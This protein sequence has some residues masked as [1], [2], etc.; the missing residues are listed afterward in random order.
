ML[1]IT[2]IMLAFHPTIDL[3]RF[4][5][6]DIFDVR[7]AVG[8]SISC[9]LVVRHLHC[10]VRIVQS[11][12]YSDKKLQQTV[13]LLSTSALSFLMDSSFLLSSFH[14]PYHGGGTVD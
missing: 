4:C 1:P 13:L 8:C 12:F 7:H 3:H 9:N 5:S 14:A 2:P 11:S 6:S 10:A